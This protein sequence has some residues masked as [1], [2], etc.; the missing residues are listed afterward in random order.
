MPVKRLTDGRLCG[1]ARMLSCARLQ[2]GLL[3]GILLAA[4]LAS[5]GVHRGKAKLI[6]DAIEQGNVGL[7]LR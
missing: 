1:C 5:V 4:V 7:H 2:S 6:V 3:L